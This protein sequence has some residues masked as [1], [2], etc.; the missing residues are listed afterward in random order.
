MVMSDIYLMCS[1]NSKG[2]IVPIRV[3]E[4]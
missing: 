3:V 4:I 1:V 2:N